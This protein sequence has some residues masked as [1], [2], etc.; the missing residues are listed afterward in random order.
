MK[1]ILIEYHDKAGMTKIECNK[2]SGEHILDA[3]WDPTEKQTPENR[4]KFRNWTVGMLK[5]KGYEVDE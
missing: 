2:P 4:I 1:A 3:L 5:R